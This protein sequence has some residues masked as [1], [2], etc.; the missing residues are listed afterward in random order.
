[1]KNKS[2]RSKRVRKSNYDARLIKEIIDLRKTYGRLGKEKIYY[3]L[4]EKELATVSVSTIGTMIKFLKEKNQIDEDRY[5]MRM[6][7]AMGKAKEEGDIQIDT[8]VEIKNGIRHCIIQ[9][10]DVYNRMSFNYAYKRGLS[11]SAK[12]FVMKLQRVLPYKIKRIQTDNGSEFE[13]DFTN[14]LEKETDIYLKLY[15][16][17]KL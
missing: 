14:Y 10:I 5:K 11:G 3:L 8:I 13:K 1:M 7:G 4:K 6:N 16:L 2:R 15:S 9:G 12:D 17:Q